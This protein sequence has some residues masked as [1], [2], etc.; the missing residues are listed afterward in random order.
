LLTAFCEPW[1]LASRELIFRHSQ[2]GDH[3]LRSC[4]LW[5]RHNCKGSS[6]SYRPSESGP[7]RA[8]RLC[9]G[10]AKWETFPGAAQPL[11]FKSRFERRHC[12]IS[13]DCWLFWTHRYDA[14]RIHRKDT[15]LAHN[16]LVGKRAGS[17]LVEIMKSHCLVSRARWLLRSSATLWAVGARQDS[18]G[19]PAGPAVNSSLFYSGS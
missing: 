5:A 11:S 7:A 2:D 16:F 17:L 10:D 6:A 19:C 12:T 3:L 18:H 15:S 13:V 1:Q 9:P 8:L 14:L 4:V